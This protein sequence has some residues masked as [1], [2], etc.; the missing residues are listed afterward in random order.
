[1][2]GRWVYD[3]SVQPLLGSFGVG[4]REIF[5]ISVAQADLP[6]GWPAASVSMARFCWASMLAAKSRNMQGK[7]GTERLGS[8]AAMPVLNGRRISCSS[9]SSCVPVDPLMSA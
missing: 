8:I 7:A 6:E 5:L 9:C 3:G 4:M 1:M 2:S